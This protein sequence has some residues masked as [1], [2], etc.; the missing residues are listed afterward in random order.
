[1][2]FDIGEAPY[3]NPVNELN[4]ATH[5]D[6]VADSQSSTD[7]DGDI[8]FINTFNVCF[9]FLQ[10]NFRL[11]SSSDVRRVGLDTSFLEG[12]LRHSHWMTKDNK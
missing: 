8:L 10:E 1:M 2:K 4:S 11:K 3:A 9:R 7:S 6:G 5:S 12:N